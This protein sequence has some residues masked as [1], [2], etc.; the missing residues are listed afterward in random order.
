MFF[1]SAGQATYDIVLEVL[2]DDEPE[3]DEVVQVILT[4]VSPSNTQRIKASARQ[5]WVRILENDNP[6]GTF[7]FIET[8]QKEYIIR[9]SFLKRTL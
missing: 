1:R 4:S 7:S 5:V 9:V 6:G 3:T 2:P 8:M